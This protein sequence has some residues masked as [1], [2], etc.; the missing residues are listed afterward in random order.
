MTW[1]V[2]HADFVVLF[3]K[4]Y[5]MSK[6]PL[7]RFNFSTRLSRRTDGKKFASTG[8]PIKKDLYA[9]LG[10]DGK[11]DWKLKKNGTLVSGVYPKQKCYLRVMQCTESQPTLFS[12]MITVEPGEKSRV[13]LRGVE[14]SPGTRLEGNLDASVKRPVKNGFVVG[15]IYEPMEPES[16]KTTWGWSDKATIEEDGSFV[17][18]SLPRDAVLQMI[19]VCDE[20]VP[21]QPTFESVAENFPDEAADFN[22]R[23]KGFCLPQF[24]K[25]SGNEASVTLRMTPSASVKATFIG[26]DGKPRSEVKTHMWPNQYWL[27]GGSNILGEGYPSR[28]SM[29]AQRRGEEIEW[30]KRGRFSSVSDTDGVC[31]IKNLP[32]M[33]AESLAADHDKFEL[34]ITDGDREIRFELKEGEQKELT[35]KLQAKGEGPKLGEGAAD[36]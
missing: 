16:W 15:C 13:L 20:W 26:P 19:A 21:A 12:D 3:R 7:L 8:K 5:G 10:L 28:D 11:S 1:S 17:F 29:V 31:V 18:E 22:G 14:L 23:I 32:P 30:P 2:D 25:L 33:A 36:D 24:A 9:V 4:D 35:I 27:K 6:M 34:P